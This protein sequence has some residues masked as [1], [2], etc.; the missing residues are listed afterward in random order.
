M[1]GGIA[2]VL[3]ELEEFKDSCNTEMVALELLDDNDL[4]TLKTMIEK[5][6]ELT[7]SARGTIILLN[8]RTYAHKFVKVMPM[9]YKRVLQAL[10]RAT[11]SGLSGD[12]ALAAA[13]AENVE[14]E[15]TH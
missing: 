15:H 10:E 6:A 4:E 11:T 9:D 7:G 13:F 3:D 1:C 12:E 14:L 5:H 8:W 2:Y